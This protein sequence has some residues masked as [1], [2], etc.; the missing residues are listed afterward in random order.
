MIDLE[1]Q[2]FADTFGNPKTDPYLAKTLVSKGALLDN[3]YGIGHDSLDN[4]IAQVSG[5]APNFQTGADCG[6]Y[7]PFTPL[8]GETSRLHQGRPAL[9]RR[10][11]LPEQRQDDRQ[12]ARRGGQ[13]VERL[14]RGHGQRPSR[15][16]TVET[17]AGPACGH[18]ALGA[19]DLTDDLT[20]RNDSY[21]TR[22]NPFMYFESVI[23][24]QAYCDTHVVSFKPLAQ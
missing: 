2:S 5:Q 3:Y 13:D 15:D 7:T 1:N 19:E 6:V 22:H 12:P 20:P 4:Y 24:N 23:G 21:A 14:R 16:G 10:L 17:T 8:G 18:P 11:R 9:R